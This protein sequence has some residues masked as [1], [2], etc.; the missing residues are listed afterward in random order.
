MGTPLI[1][2]ASPPSGATA[3]TRRRREAR[4]LFLGD[5]LERTAWAVWRSQR[6]LQL[7][8][9]AT[10]KLLDLLL[11][12]EHLQVAH[13]TRCT[14]G[15]TRTSARTRLQGSDWRGSDGALTGMLLARVSSLAGQHSSWPA[16]RLAYAGVRGCKEGLLA[17]APH[18]AYPPP[19]PPTSSA[20]P[21]PPLNPAIWG[22]RERTTGRQQ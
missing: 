5:A 10:L 9:G 14:H 17:R 11:L 7:L 21:L 13:D 8:G 18:H 4:C 12:C 15:C 3:W 19:P 20:P 2:T 22:S 6:R 16:R 1:V